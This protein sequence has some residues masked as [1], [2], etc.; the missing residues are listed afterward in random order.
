MTT[1]ELTHDDHFLDAQAAHGHGRRRPGRVHRRRAPDCRRA[2]RTD[3]AYGRRLLARLSEHA[4]DGEKPLSRS[5]AARIGAPP[6]WPRPK[7]HG[8]LQIASTSSASSRRTTRISRPAKAFL[9]AGFHVVCDKPL[10]L[11]LEQAEELA[12]DCRE[13]RARVRADAQLHR[14]SARAARATSVSIGADGHGPQG[15]RRVSAGLA[16]GAAREAGLEAGGVANQSRGIGHRRRDRRHRH[17]RV[18]PGRVRDRRPGSAA[19]ART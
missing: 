8:R 11:T 6:R 16:D 15:H 18:Q 7:R 4:D 10:A 2:R 5:R 19:S 17:A 9:E 12:R 13:D 14:L 3:R 1:T